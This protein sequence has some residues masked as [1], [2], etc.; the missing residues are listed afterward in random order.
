MINKEIIVEQEWRNHSTYRP[1]DNKSEFLSAQKEHGIYLQEK[2]HKACI[3]P[4]FVNDYMV[5]VH[6]YE[7]K[8]EEFSYKQLLLSFIWQDGTPCGVKK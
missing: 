3:F 6:D 1:Y 4:F 5:V 8:P 7:Y 2:E